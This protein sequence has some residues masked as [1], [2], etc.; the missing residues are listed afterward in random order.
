MGK[1]RHY[2]TLNFGKHKTFGQNKNVVIKNNNLNQIN[3]QNLNIKF[4]LSYNR[5]SNKGAVILHLLLQSQVCVSVSTFDLF[6]KIQSFSHLE[7]NVKLWCRRRKNGMMS[8]HCFWLNRQMTMIL[9]N[10]SYTS[11]G[12]YQVSTMP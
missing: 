7:Y 8:L 1:S 3:Q 11:I 10:K 5:T 9:Y 12:T 4:H 2:K 6:S